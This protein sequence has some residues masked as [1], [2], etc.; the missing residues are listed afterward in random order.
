M[1]ALL[2]AWHIKKGANNFPINTR[3][4]TDIVYRPNNFSEATVLLDDSLSDYTDEF[5]GED[6]V[7]V[8]IGD[9]DVFSVKMLTGIIDE[10]DT[11]REA[12]RRRMINLHLVDWGSYL[13]AKRI[14]EKKYFRS[15]TVNNILSD[16][17][18]SVTDG[19]D[20]L[21][22]NNIESVAEQLKQFFEGTYVKDIWNRC[23]EIG[24]LDYFV[25]ENLDL[26]AFT[27]GSKL[28]Q[29][30]GLTYKI[31]DTAS[32]AANQIMV[33]FTKPYNF[34]LDSAQRY[35]NVKV[36]NGNIEYHPKELDSFQVDRF[37]HD[38]L[39]KTFSQYYIISLDDYDVDIVGTSINP[40][41]FIADELLDPQTPSIT[42]PVARLVVIG[43]SQPVGIGIFPHNNLVPTTGFQI[44]IDQWDEISFWIKNNL[45][46]P[47]LTSFKIIIRE[48]GLNF[49]ELEM[50][51]NDILNPDWIYHRLK[52]PKTNDNTEVYTGSSWSKT[53]NPTKLNTINFVPTPTTGFDAFSTISFSQMF[54]YRSL[55][56]LVIGAGNP[57][58]QKI[59]IDKSLTSLAQLQQFTTSEQ[60]RTNQEIKSGSCTIMGNTDFKKPAYKID[61][62]FTSTLGA[63]RSG[64]VRMDNIRHYL[65]DGIHLTDIVFNNSF[66]RP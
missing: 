21:T 49:W 7:E 51:N 29:T 31:Q 22:G 61:V 4:G 24:K 65:E 16:T 40:V 63:G 38:L 39:G 62:D 60:S 55:F 59:I 32:G 56:A 13:A 6:K 50:I 52:L 36:T 43:P 15:R 48:D 18:S 33:R 45:T 44:D 58:T 19:T 20:T 8:H 9:P 54:L 26:N 53:G 1:S 28:L 42:R 23:A 41:Q 12:S 47:T 37:H 3:N 66:Y 11:R 14:F 5:V 10:I 57:P 30:G 27:T 25:D 34:V 2:P 46:G 64:T 35:R 17:L